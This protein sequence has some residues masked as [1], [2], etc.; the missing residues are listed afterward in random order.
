MDSFSFMPIQKI[1]QQVTI[2]LEEYIAILRIEYWFKN[3]FMLPGMVFASLFFDITFSWSLVLMMLLGILATCLIASANYVINEWLDA[4]FDKFHPVKKHRPSVVKELSPQIIYLEY[5]ILAIVGL[6][7]AFYI[8]TL[9]LLSEVLLLIMGLLYNVEPIRTKDKVY[10]DVLSES[11]NNPIRLA[12]GWFIFVPTSFPPSSMLVAYWMGGAFLMGTKR[13]A[14][15]RFI[16]DPQRAGLY[17]K[18]FKHYTEQNLLMSIFF[19]ALTSTFFLGIF[20]IKYRIE[21]LLSFPLFALLFTWYLQIGFKENS[22]AQYPEKL[23]KE[24]HFMLFLVT[25]CTVIFILLFVDIPWLHFL[26][27]S[28]FG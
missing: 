28:N 26:L 11:I 1:Y 23:Y 25:L 4:E 14:E 12:L 22:P 27:K 13:F 2:N 20:L 18:S 24:K 15:Y 21:L 17:R 16:N 7:I 8:N 10:L 5:V 9:F 19:Y 6:A 3:I